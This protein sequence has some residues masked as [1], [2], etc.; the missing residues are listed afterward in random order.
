MGADEIRGSGGDDLLYGGGGRDT[1]S[2]GEGADTLS[3]GRGRD[4]FV[5]N[6]LDEAGD[7]VTDFDVTVASGETEPDSSTSDTMLMVDNSSIEDMNLELAGTEND[8]NSSDED[9]DSE[10]EESLEPAGPF[11]G[12]YLVDSGQQGPF[13]EGI[14]SSEER[15][16]LEKYSHEISYDKHFI[17]TPDLYEEDILISLEIV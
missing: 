5:I 17:Q 8:S 14:F 3:G 11:Y 7:T 1:L 6:T 2:G 13:F 15:D 10:N 12:N 16:Y 9:E 4:T